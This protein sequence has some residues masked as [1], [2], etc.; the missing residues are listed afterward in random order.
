MKT[1]L[2]FAGTRPEIIKMAP[3]VR[4]LR[5]RQRSQTARKKTW[6]AHFCFSG[7]HYELALP[8]LRYFDTKP[9]SQLDVMESGQSL[10]QLRSRATAQLDA[11]FKCH[12]G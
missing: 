2:V 8:F 5:A 6:S 4:E 7:Q 10:G 9:D 11:F 3:V 12:P 1:I